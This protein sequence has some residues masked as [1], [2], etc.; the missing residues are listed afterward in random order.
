VIVG[1]LFAAVAIVL[2]ML[3]L[4]RANNL[5]LRNALLAVALC[6]GAWGLVSWAIASAV[7]Q[8]E[9]DSASRHDEDD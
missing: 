5:S 2:T 9:E 6:G 4:W 3:G 1:G 8:V 7:V